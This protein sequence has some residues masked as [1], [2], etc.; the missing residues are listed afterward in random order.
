MGGPLEVSLG[1]IKRLQRC[2]NDLVSVLALPAIWAG[3]EP[4]QVIRTLLPALQG[5][6]DL[7][8]ACVRL[9][10]PFGEPTLGMT[11]DAQSRELA[12]PSAEISE[13]LDQFVR[14]DSKKWPDQ[15][16]SRIR[17]ADLSIAAS[18]LGLQGE[19][20]ILVAGSRREDFPGQTERLVL[21]VAAN[22]AAI[23]LQ[24]A[25]LLSEQKRVA[26]ELD[27]RVVQRTQELADSN[28]ALRMQV[29]LLQLIPVA[30]WTLKPDGTPDFVNDTW[31]EYSGQ[32]L[33]FVRSRPGAWMAAVHPEDR[34]IASKSFWEGVR[35]G[36]GFA[37][38]TRLFRMQDGTYRWHLNRAVVLRDT[39][40]KIL[41]FVG[42]STD[43]EDVKRS[44]ESLRTAE[45]R[46]RLI[47]DT[48][49]EAVITM[50][51]QGT[52]T[53]WNKQ[54]E[55]IFGWDSNDAVGQRMSHL[56]IP[57]Q[58][59]AAHECGLRH[60]L[61][62]GDGP[63][64]RRRV[65][66]TAVRR[67]GMEFPVELQVT[68]MR[69]GQE[70][71]FSAFI[72]DITDAK[73]A[74]ETLRKSEL[75]FRQIVDSIPGLV[76]TMSPAGEI[77]QL[78]QQLLEY[79]GKTPAELKSWN[80]IDAVHP[81][82]RRRVLTAFTHSIATGTPYEIEHRCR[83]AD[84]VYRWFQV[85]ALAM[86][87]ANGMVTGWYMLLTD[88]EDRKRAEDELRR[89]EAFLAQGQRLNLT[90]TFSWCL[91]TNEITFSEQLYH[92]F[93][94]VP[95]APVTLEKIRGRVHPED[96]PLLVE[97]IDLARRGIKDLDYE[98]RLRMP[99]GSI[100][101]LRTNAFGMRDRDGRLEYMGAIQ[102]VTERRL[103]EEALGKLR[104]ELAHMA[105]VTSL[106]ALTA[107]IAHEVNQPLSGIVTNANTCVRML[108][109][110]PPNIDGALETAR[111]TIRD[112]NRASEVI[113][114]LRALFSKKETA[115]EDL[116]LNEAAR[117]VIS[118]TL[119]ELQR[120]RVILR[121][122]LADDLP[123]VRGDRVQLQQ[124][125]L[126][127]LRNASDA[128]SNVE[129]RP[130]NLVIKTARDEDNCVR[131]AVQD[132][133][134]GVDSQSLG[135]LFD[136]FYS[137]KSAGMGMGLSVSRTIIESHHGRLWATPNEGPGAIFSFSVPLKPVSTDTNGPGVVDTPIATDSVKAVRKS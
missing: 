35:S 67:G 84:G 11:W 77:E 39:N 137:T 21:N 62:T 99:D 50:D 74:E 87:D 116:D 66:F 133:G 106:G 81:D 15:V 49:L 71:A 110:N 40:G 70:W 43:I 63:I 44:Q 37:M 2:V 97:K 9:N 4:S 111:R 25:Q 28:E 45:E 24:A 125:I 88:I 76:C 33:E 42:T 91:D 100:K 117:E 7:D 132:A 108:S 95:D 52:I 86:R 131:L 122:E 47:I 114:R 80:M 64:L 94:L 129:D 46:T 31:L 112:G 61:A 65:E 6:L 96:I 107:S 1:E 130:R 78:N 55:V 8:L 105:R 113:A 48:A 57:E 134:V 53:S 22:Q 3:G 72:R 32:T 135:K 109:A 69:L 18:P 92:I 68:P 38:E 56:I 83:R 115:N 59:Q 29:G 36:Q 118:L 20:G 124:V 13:L 60:F 128:M 73:V 17:N 90:G 16:R 51:A 5:M 126:N 41:R 121:Q 89:S 127:L 30:A 98:I 103:A 136:P 79:F 26:G 104:L 119:S 14:D 27:R 23:G 12:A 54:A 10:D 58:Q 93:E 19:I 34:E 120:N 75:K 123:P 82:D 85:R 101:Y 102:D